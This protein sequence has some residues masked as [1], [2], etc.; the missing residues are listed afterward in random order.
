MLASLVSP[1]HSTTDAPAAGD[2]QGHDDHH[3]DRA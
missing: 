1:P 2:K 3:R